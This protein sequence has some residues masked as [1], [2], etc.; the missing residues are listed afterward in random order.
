MQARTIVTLVV[1]VLLGFVAFLV[2]ANWAGAYT[3]ISPT[4]PTIS[5]T[6]PANQGTAALEIVFHETSHGMMEKVMN[7][8]QA[9]EKAFNSQRTGKVFHAGSL[10]HAV[11]FYTAGQLVAE[12][13]HGY[14]PY[15]DKNGLWVRAWPDPN[16]KLIEQDWKPHMNGS[17][18]LQQSLAKLVSDLASASSA[19]QN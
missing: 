3:T 4:R 17:V 12:Q 5:T 13:V 11:L 10:W 1:A 18:S 14:T 8:M 2:Y 6:D 16:R 9:A 19:P 7:A 15:A